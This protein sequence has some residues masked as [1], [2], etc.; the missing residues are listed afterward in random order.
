MYTTTSRYHAYTSLS[1]S[2]EL[3]E[4]FIKLPSARQSLASIATPSLTSVDPVNNSMFPTHPLAWL[5][6]M[7]IILTLTKYEPLLSHLSGVILIQRK[8][9]LLVPHTKQHSIKFHGIAVSDTGYPCSSEPC[10]HDALAL[11]P[12][13]RD[14]VRASSSYKCGCYPILIPA[15]FL[16]NVSIQ[17]WRVTACVNTTG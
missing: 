15:L 3:T 17:V 10:L 16:R 6:L 12:K 8:N 2:T 14:M 11:E 9:S 13:R 5:T 4:I 1:R 7:K